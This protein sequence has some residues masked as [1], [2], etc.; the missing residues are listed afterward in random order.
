RAPDEVCALRREPDDGRTAVTRVRPTLYELPRLEP[1]DAAGHRAGAGA[2]AL[3]E[4]RLRD[5]GKVSSIARQCGQCGVLG[6]GE[7]KRRH[8]S[9]GRVLHEEAGTLHP[10]QRLAAAAA[11]ALGTGWRV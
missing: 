3:D 9:G 10:P 7:P 6:E 5:R 2:R 4:M 1:V 11:I 8:D